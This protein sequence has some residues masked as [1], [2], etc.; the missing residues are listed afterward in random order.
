MNIFA[1]DM[2]EQLLMDL[3]LNLKAVVSQRLVPSLDGKLACAVEVMMNTPRISELIREGSFSEIKELM[4]KG[5]TP[6]I[7]TFDQSLFDLFTTGKISKKN[8]L[9]FAD[10]SSNLEWK[11][12]FGDQQ[13]QG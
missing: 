2:R 9:E 12:N 7:Q 5:D 10:S 3:S 1:T 8:A 11:M 6:E 13:A 4:D